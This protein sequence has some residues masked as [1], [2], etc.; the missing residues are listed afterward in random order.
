MTEFEKNIK[1]KETESGHIYVESRTSVSL[2]GQA[3]STDPDCFLYVKDVAE[4]IQKFINFYGSM[5][6]QDLRRV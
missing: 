4:A 5:Y 1:Y 6:E 3:Y 2:Y